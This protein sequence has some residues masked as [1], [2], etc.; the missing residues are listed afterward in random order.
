MENTIVWFV[1]LAPASLSNDDGNDA[2]MYVSSVMMLILMMMVMMMT[3][4]LLY[5]SSDDSLVSKTTHSKQ[6]LIW[7]SDIR[8]KSSLLEWCFWAHKIFQ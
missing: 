5:T 8:N 4:V 2:M 1:L 7:N 6:L 3:V